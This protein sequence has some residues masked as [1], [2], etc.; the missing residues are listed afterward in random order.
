MLEGRSLICRFQA[1]GH[2]DDGKDNK[3]PA[4]GLK[5]ASVSGTF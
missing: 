3:A 2:V 4:Q 1:A 5:T